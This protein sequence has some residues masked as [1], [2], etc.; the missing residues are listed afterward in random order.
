MNIPKIT[1]LKIV[2]IKNP[3]PFDFYLPKHNCCIEYQGRQHYSE[4][5]YNR[6]TRDSNRGEG[7]ESLQKE[8]KSK[9]I[10]AERKI[11]YI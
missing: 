10:I 9:E 11:Y 3:L 2:D 1:D 7:F 6:L 8:I 4:K 5:D